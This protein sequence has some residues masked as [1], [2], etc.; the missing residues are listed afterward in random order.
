MTEM[1]AKTELTLDERALLEQAGL[2]SGDVSA[3]LAAY[4]ELRN[5][6]SADSWACSNWWA[7][8]ERLRTRLPKRAAREVNVIAAS[9]LIHAKERALR[10][11][12]LSIHL[13]ALYDE[14]TARR[15]KFRRVED[16]MPAAAALVP[17]LTPSAEAMARERALPLKQ[18][19]KL[20]MDHGILL[21]HVLA[22]PEAGRH[23]CHAMLLPRTE[24]LDLLPRLVRDGL[25][26]LGTARASRIGKASIVELRNLRALNALDETTLAPLETAID[27]AIL[28]PSTEIAVLR[29]GR[30]EHP[31]YAGRRIFSA[32]INLTH[33]YQGKIS[34]LFYFLHV[35]GYENK[36]LRGIA[37]REVSPDDQAGST[38]EKPWIAAVDT[39]A[40][41]GGCQHLLVMDYVLAEA[42]AY[43]TLPARKEGIIPGMANLRLPRF[44]GDRL[45]RQAIMYGRRI[46]CDSPEG[47]LICDE[48]ASADR[49]DAALAHVVEGLTSSGLVSAV[50]NRR[51]FRIGQEPLDIFRRYLSLFAK[52]QAD[53]HFSDG[54]IS[55]LERY[56]NAQSRDIQAAAN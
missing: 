2:A 56:W 25:I 34:F 27:L 30:V 31:K 54:L 26:D 18:K 4:P 10:E 16:L 15:S 17:G 52:E 37:R 50:G 47:R 53:C 21:S 19:E 14:L 29:G 6:F 35:M 28:D 7:L 8:S 9:E 55:N 48:I 45:A 40:I 36:I 46:E 22:N 38:V 39:F 11:Q 20:E 42:G 23:L 5:D 49:M 13:E 1:N 12:F 44:V 33:L 24:T 3:W 41:G 51:Q 32:G 43:L